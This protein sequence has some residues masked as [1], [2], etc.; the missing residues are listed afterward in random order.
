[1]LILKPLNILTAYN[2]HTSIFG[3]NA[4]LWS[5]YNLFDYKYIGYIWNG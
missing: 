3:Y 4:E 1:M 2:E 5:F